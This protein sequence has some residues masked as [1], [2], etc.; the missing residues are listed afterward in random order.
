M[1]ILYA[2]NDIDDFDF[3]DEVIR[4]FYPDSECVNAVNGIEALEFLDTSERLPD[5]IVIDINMPAMDG[6]ACLKAIKSDARFCAIPVIIYSTSRDPR[7]I[8]ICMELGA[9][10]Y[11]M[12]PNTMEEAVAGLSKYF[13]LDAGGKSM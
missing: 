8:A 11:L 1:L 13:K 6:K 9:A 3:L 4:S 10:D 12:K 2:E 7:D 5:Y